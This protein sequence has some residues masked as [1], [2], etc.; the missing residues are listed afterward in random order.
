[1]KLQTPLVLTESYLWSNFDSQDQLLYVKVE[2]T[3]KQNRL[4]LN[5]I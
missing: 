4:I 2:V 3:E 1:M 5:Y